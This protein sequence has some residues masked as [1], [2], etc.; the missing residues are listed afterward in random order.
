MTN[1]DFLLQEPQFEAFAE[2][3]VAAEKVINIDIPTCVVNCRRAAEFAVKWMYSVDKA[4][5]MPYQDKFV[6]LMNTPQFVDMI[7]KDIYKR[8][9]YIRVLGNSGNHSNKKISREQ[10]ELDLQ[11]LFIFLDFVA[12]CYSKNGYIERNFDVKLLSRMQEVITTVATPEVDIQVLMD[13]NKPLREEYTKRRKVQETAYVPKPL[14]LTEY[15]TRKTYID[16]MLQDA[17]WLEGE[18]WINEYPVINMPSASGKGKVD[19]VLFGDDSR[20]LAIIEAKKTCKSAREG[21]Q[22]AKLYAD[23]LEKKFGRRP[24]I[25][26]TNGFDTRIWNDKFYSER[27]VSGIYSKRDLE[28]KFNKLTM[29]TS[30]QNVKINDAISNRYY[31]KEAIKAV[32]ESFDRENRRKALLVMATGSGKTRTII[33]LVEILLN[34]GWVKNVLFLADR[35]SLVTQAKRAFVNLLPD[36][37]ITNLCEDKT[38]LN[39][40]CVFS[41]YQTMMNCIDDAKDEEGGKL[42]TC[43]HFDLLICDEAHRSIY[44]KYQDIFTYFDAF[45]VGLTATPKDEVGKNTYRIFELEDRVP[46]YGYELSQA[47]KDGY[48]VDFISVETPLKF[49]EKGIF[50]DELTEEEKEEYEENFTDENGDVPENISSTAINDWVFNKDTIRKALDIL[51]TKGIKVDYGQNVGKTIIFARNHNHAEMIY[52]IFREEY[53]SYDSNY[54]RVIDN[55]VN[56]AQS[57]L[58]EFSDAKTFPQIAVSVDMLDT[59]IDVPEC[60]NLVFFKKVYSKAKF[61]QMIGRGTR[62][63]PGLL[64][65]EDKKIF[66]IFDFCG[67]FEFFRMFKG[68]ETP[69]QGTVQERIFLLKAEMIYKLQPMEYQTEELMPFRDDLVKDCIAKVRELSRDNFAVKQH[70]RYVDLYKNPEAYKALTY[71]KIQ[72]MQE[73]LAPLILPYEDEIQAVR[74]DAL[75]YGIELASLAGKS[76]AKAKADVMKKVRAIANISTIPEIL[77]QKELIQKVLK[78]SFWESAGIRDFEQVREKLRNLMKY[79]QGQEERKYTIDLEDDVLSM[80]WNDSDLENE[81]LKDYKAKAAFYLKQHQN[82][83][84]IAKLRTNKP[85]TN[86]DIKKLEK[87]LWS[88][89]GSREE[90]EAECGN[91]PLG[92]FVRE[93]VGLDMNAAKEAFSVFLEGSNLN[94]NQINFINRIIEYIVRNGMMADLTVLQD[95]P[96]TDRGSIVDLFADMKVWNGIRNT[97]EEINHNALIA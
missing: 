1:F 62:L 82:E 25:F 88:E 27:R 50:Y 23:S 8:L 24:I 89:V 90:Y 57:L 61:W 81:D 31:Q 17:G 2:T 59:G 40:R 77:H 93:V 80:T 36:L 84:V 73:E 66:Y 43:G 9:D 5:K 35:N 87:I 83:D 65:G 37:S 3:A 34:A 32:C 48:L 16:T 75:L 38:N 94:A 41:T 44:K 71:E 56:F 12:C 86:L 68:K 46:T 13:E 19:Y 63:C 33:S 10:A 11:N 21:Q 95:T 45:L 96:F 42:Y 29:R 91:K 30:L 53:P 7:G 28:K 26:L 69:V 49:V 14:D 15:E 51:M 79:I 6:T 70:L 18:D 58:D 64:D 72:Q 22:Q 52:D 39:A 78:E 92:V 4:L 20:P 55:T 67:N 60:V 97:I 85:L 76:Y 47:V 74:F 54:C